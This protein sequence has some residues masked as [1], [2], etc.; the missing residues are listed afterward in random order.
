[1]VYPQQVHMRDPSNT[2]RV[3]DPNTTSL[4][5]TTTSAIKHTIAYANSTTCHC[6]LHGTEQKRREAGQAA[7]AERGAHQ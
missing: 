1:M 6:T 2:E 4:C 7:A 3:R 5:C